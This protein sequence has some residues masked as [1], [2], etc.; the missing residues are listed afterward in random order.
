MIRKQVYIR[1]DQEKRL[2]AL[3]AA[4]GKAEA[5]LIR[6]GIDKVLAEQAD[7]QQDWK[8]AWMRAYGLWA[9]REDIEDIM[10]ENRRR[11]R[12]RMDRLFEGKYKDDQDDDPA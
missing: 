5:E 1:E 12:R 9:D 3:A 8:A 2:K 10:A 6:E 7:L 4:V 11:V